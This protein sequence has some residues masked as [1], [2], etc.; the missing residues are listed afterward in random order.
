L[1]KKFGDQALSI[2]I[3]PP[4]VQVLAQR[5]RS[6]NTDSEDRIKQRL[7]KAKQEIEMSEAFDII[8][9]N[10]ILELAIQKATKAV[11]EFLAL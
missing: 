7:A 5:L 10:D 8:I 9:E 3:M 11:N 4:S 1:E 2:F 6:R